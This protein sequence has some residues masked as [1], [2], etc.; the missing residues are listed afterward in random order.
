[1]FSSSFSCAGRR[2]FGAFVEEYSKP[3]PGSFVDVESGLELGKCKN[4]LSIT[5][6]QKSGL[7]GQ[8]EKY[9]IQSSSAIVSRNHGDQ[10]P[11]HA[12][13]E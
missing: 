10:V 5:L 13:A 12:V 7:S 8:K 1:M 2:S 6:G 11:I 3:V 9:V 4:I